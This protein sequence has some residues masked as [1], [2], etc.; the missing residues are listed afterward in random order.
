MDDPRIA[1]RVYLAERILATYVGQASGRDVLGEVCCED[2][3]DPVL[4]ELL[5]LFEHQPAKSR[6]WGLSGRAYDKYVDRV[7]ALAAAVVADP[8]TAPRC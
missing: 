7:R 5:D 3:D 2:F 4:D 1:R 6:W 8:H